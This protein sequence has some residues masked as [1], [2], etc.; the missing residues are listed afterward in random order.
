MTSPHRLEWGERREWLVTNGTGSYAMG[1][2]AGVR[3]RRYHGL[4]VWASDPPAHRMMLVSEVGDQ[5]LFNGVWYDLSTRRWKDGTV[6]PAG[7]ALISGFSIDDGMPTWTYTFG[8]DTLVRRILMEPARPVTLVIWEWNGTEPIALRSAVLLVHRD[9]HASMHAGNAPTFSLARGGVDVE[10]T[11]DEP[12]SVRIR[13]RCPQATMREG[14]GWWHG[15]H[16]AEEEA[17][18]YEADEDVF[19]AADV[20]LI[21]APGQVSTLAIGAVEPSGIAGLDAL[22]RQRAAVKLKTSAAVDGAFHRAHRQLLLAADQFIVTRVVDEIGEVPAVIA[23][24][25]WF[26]DWGRDTMLSLRGLFLTSGRLR[27]AGQLLVA[28]ASL[29][30]DGLLP[31]RFPDQA[32]NL[33]EFNSADAPLLFIRAIGQFQDAGGD[34]PTLL[35][36]L[37]AIRSIIAAYRDGTHFGIRVDPSDGLVEASAEGVQLT[38]MDAKVGDLVVTPRRGKPIELSALWHHALIVAASIERL[39]GES[40]RAQEDLTLAQ[41]T[42]HG[43]ARFWD[44]SLGYFKDVLDGPTGDDATLRPNQLFALDHLEGLVDERCARLAIESVRIHLLS[45][46]GVRTL[47]PSHLGYCPSYTGDVHHRDRAYHNGT[48]WPFLAALLDRA[49]GIRAMNQDTRDAL[50]V[51]FAEH[52]AEGGVGSVNEILDAD[53][54]HTPR[55]CPMQAWS[56]AA[57]LELFG[58]GR[59]SSPIV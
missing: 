10:W 24:Y 11:A 47:P 18:G 28:W 35:T 5:V 7:F 4:L 37:P 43:F 44:E 34:R 40:S 27:E 57:A 2:V 54:P 49:L 51:A 19:H 59:I 46:I 16:L 22:R 48:M 1:T 55:G 12:P 56:V 53:E 13:L 9:A 39:C 42:A 26:A 45:G 58:T 32:E 29:L 14:S 20:E 36:L 15:Q 8:R 21:L 3:T 41:A 25:P 23:G 6:S 38:W 31:N 33:V 52:L 50:R 30:R 17:R